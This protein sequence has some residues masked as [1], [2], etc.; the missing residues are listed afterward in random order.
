MTDK[1]REFIQEN[2]GAP[3]Q[4]LLKH[5]SSSE[6][7]QIRR[8]GQNFYNRGIYD[9]I[10]PTDMDDGAMTAFQRIL[11]TLA[12]ETTDK[13]RAW[14]ELTSCESERQQYGV[15]MV[16]L[17]HHQQEEVRGKREQRAT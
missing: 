9:K 8:G 1:A 10:D 13:F 14:A 6:V 7:D 3:E 15:P 16:F 11:G 2:Y 12:R 5:R 4:R 17:V